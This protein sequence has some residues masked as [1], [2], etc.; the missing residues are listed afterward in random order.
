MLSTWKSFEWDIW[1]AHCK[2]INKKI[3]ATYAI[4]KGGFKTPAKRTPDIVAN[5]LRSHFLKKKKTKQ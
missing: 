5:L 2:K 3:E 4:I 1:K